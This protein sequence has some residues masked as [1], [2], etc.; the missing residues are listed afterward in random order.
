MAARMGMMK[1]LSGDRL[2]NTRHRHDTGFMRTNLPASDG[3]THLLKKFSIL[4]TRE[5]KVPTC[6]NRCR[7]LAN[8]T[9]NGN[10]LSQSEQVLRYQTEDN[11]S[12][13]CTLDANFSVSTSRRELP[14]RQCK[15]TDSIRMSPNV[16]KDY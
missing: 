10:E 6:N 3:I 4:E 8:A 14:L 9:Q 12:R 1:G 13:V 7:Q 16:K 5:K 2:G 15:V 11:P